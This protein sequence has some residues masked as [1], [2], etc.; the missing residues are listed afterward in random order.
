MCKNLGVL[1]YR[2]VNSTK[3]LSKVAPQTLHGILSSSLGLKSYRSPQP[4]NQF[5]QISAKNV[6]FFGGISETNRENISSILSNSPR[7][8]LEKICYS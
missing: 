8:F 3:K 4:P 5:A 6:L 7:L 2:K 1:G